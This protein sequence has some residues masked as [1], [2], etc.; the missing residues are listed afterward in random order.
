MD[1]SSFFIDKKA[2]FGS[3]PTQANVDILEEEGVRVFVNLTCEHEKKITPYLTKYKYISFPIPDREVPVDSRKFS[4]FINNI[5]TIIKNLENSDKIYIHCKGGHGRSGLVVAC[6]SSKI[7]EISPKHALRYT[8][9][10]HSNRKT[11]RY[12]WRCIGSPQTHLQ[13]QYVY[14]MCHT[15]TLTAQD[16]LHPDYELD[17]I[18]PLGGLFKSA[19]AAI[20]S[21]VNNTSD[22]LESVVRVVTKLK[23]EQHPYIVDI[24][25]DT[26]LRHMKS[27]CKITTTAISDIMKTRFNMYV[28][29]F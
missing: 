13:K 14:N 7:F 21:L 4:A 18:H 28:E 17:I 20:R 3:Y 10:C 6:I 2:M 1:T 15:I 29:M 11:M 8:T 22:D 5:I 23:F 24:L 19:T 26:Y 12:K 9:N 27:P 25:L 16:I